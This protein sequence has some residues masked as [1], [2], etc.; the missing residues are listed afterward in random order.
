MC[1]CQDPQLVSLKTRLQDIESKILTVTEQKNKTD[2]NYQYTSL[3]AQLIFLKFQLK[4]AIYD[5]YRLHTNE[6]CKT[7]YYDLYLSS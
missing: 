5:I 6:T 4:S 2:S 1:D 7:F 3:G